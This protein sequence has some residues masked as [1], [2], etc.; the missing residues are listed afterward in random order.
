[1]TTDACGGP[2]VVVMQNAA[3]RSDEF[4][5]DA[6]AAGRAS[7]F[8]VGGVRSD[9]MMRI[10]SISIIAASAISTSPIHGTGS[11][12]VIKRP[13]VARNLGSVIARMAQ[14]L[15]TYMNTVGTPVTSHTHHSCRVRQ[16]QMVTPSSVSAA[17]S[18]LL[19]PNK[20]QKRLH[21][22]TGAS[23]G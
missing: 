20:F 16:S 6:A 1:M 21:T 15:M 9:R 10:A 8:A 13:S 3:I 11:V 12:G 19:A 23:L 2:L 14:V 22:G 4:A 17:K 18:W 5:Y 7:S